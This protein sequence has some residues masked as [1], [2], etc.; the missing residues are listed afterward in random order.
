MS[1]TKVN[2]EERFNLQ[3]PAELKKRIE[4]KARERMLTM[5]AYVRIVLNDK[6]KEDD[7]K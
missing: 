5:S 4:A 7:A 3:L 6:L 2:K 1:D